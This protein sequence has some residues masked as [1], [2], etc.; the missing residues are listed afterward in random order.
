M[1]D[2]ACMD[3]PLGIADDQPIVQS[4]PCQKV[5]GADAGLPFW[6]ALAKDIRKRTETAMPQRHSLKT[7]RL[8]TIV[9]A[10]AAAC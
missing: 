5:S 8:P 1:S 4:S 9:R 2:A 10:I 6:A 3:I 7:A